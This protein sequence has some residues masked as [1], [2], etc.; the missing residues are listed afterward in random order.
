VRYSPTPVAPDELFGLT[1][2]P[3]GRGILFVNDSAN[4]VEIAH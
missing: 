1:L 2:T 3:D 4:N